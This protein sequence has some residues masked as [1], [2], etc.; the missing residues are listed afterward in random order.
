[1]MRHCKAPE[2][3]GGRFR[4]A[5]AQRG[6]SANY[7]AVYPGNTPENHPPTEICMLNSKQHR[8]CRV[9]DP[10]TRGKHQ[11]RKK[12]SPVYKQGAVGCRIQDPGTRGYRWWKTADFS[13]SA[14]TAH[15]RPLRT[16]GEAPMA[17]ANGPLALCL[18]AHGC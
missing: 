15:V 9:Q 4:T 12:K 17:D 5:R 7:Y 13:H 8:E 3:L 14:R 2:P 11:T 10:G 1:M 16:C 6:H 18:K